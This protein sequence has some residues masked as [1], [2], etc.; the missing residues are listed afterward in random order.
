MNHAWTGDS[1]A[2]SY[3]SRCG[4]DY[5]DGGDRESCAGGEPL[6]DRMDR[7]YS[8]YQRLLKTG[9]H[10]GDRVLS[11]K[12]VLAALVDQECAKARSEEREACARIAET[13]YRRDPDGIDA[14]WDHSAV[15]RRVQERIAEAI[16]ARRPARPPRAEERPPAQE[17]G[18]AK[19]V[20]CYRCQEHVMPPHGCVGPQ[21]LPP[22]QAPKPVE[23][24]THCSRCGRIGVHIGHVCQPPPKPVDEARV[25]EI[26]RCYDRLLTEHLRRFEAIEKRLD[27]IERRPKSHKEPQ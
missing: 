15:R 2:G 8:E 17:A 6:G 5:R 21:V 22:A 11:H 19:T 20:W 14:G 18:K 13:Q 10:V 26:V 4:K 27:A 7:L 16:R 9:L 24:E 23:P 3:C 12:T 25:E 1:S